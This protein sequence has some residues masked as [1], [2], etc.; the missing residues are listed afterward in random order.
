M[1]RRQRCAGCTGCSVHSPNDTPRPPMR[2]LTRRPP[3]QAVE[4]HHGARGSCGSC[5][6]GHRVF[7]GVRKGGSA[8]ASLVVLKMD[9]AGGDVCQRHKGQIVVA[10]GV[11]ACTTG[12]ARVSWTRDG[13]GLSVRV[14]L[15]LRVL[16]A[17]CTCGAHSGSGIQV[18]GGQLA[19]WHSCAGGQ[20]GGRLPGQ[21]GDSQGMW[22]QPQQVGMRLVETTAANGRA[23]EPR[24]I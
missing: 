10:I 21:T 5:G 15:R 4:Q 20:A 9:G 24:L 2:M 13:G 14:Q 12:G 16:S 18:Q 17:Q 7:I 23:A 22:K 1:P 19:G 11:E 6:P 8:N 3:V